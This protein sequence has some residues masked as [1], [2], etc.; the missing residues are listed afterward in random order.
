MQFF[1]VCSA[2][3]LIAS[4]ICTEAIFTGGVGI[5]AGGLLAAALGVKALA[6]FGLLL[7]SKKG[8]RR[9]GGKGH[10]KGRSR[11]G[12]SVAAVEDI[13]ALLSEAALDDETDCAKKFVCETHAK[14]LEA[15][16]ETERA[17]YLL[18]GPGNSID[19]SSES[20]QFDLAAL[21][22]RRAG[23]A[24]CQKVYARCQMDSAQMRQAMTA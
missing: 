6:G 18:F 2:F 7:A 14:A 3:L 23:V 4:F 9:G 13:P 12:R 16:D 8:G 17:I 1:L 20:V 21:V 19:V 5:T 24:Q 11:Y 15:L 22:G 10:G